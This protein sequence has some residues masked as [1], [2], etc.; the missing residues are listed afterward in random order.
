[1]KTKSTLSI[2]TMLLMGS[3]YATSTFA[4]GV[5]TSGGVDVT[6]PGVDATTSGNAN[7]V[8][9]DSATPAMP[10]TPA[11]PAD[12]MEKRGNDVRTLPNR[13]NNST[14][15]TNMRNKDCDVNVSANSNSSST[16]SA[17]TRNCDD[18]S[19]PRK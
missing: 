8:A 6:A 15:S 13:N 4:A 16:S 3:L 5:S 19:K 12:R 14:K 17:A 2:F 18:T 10:A 11:D 7:V 1:M 9:P